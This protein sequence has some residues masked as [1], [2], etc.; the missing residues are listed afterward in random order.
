MD[1]KLLYDEKYTIEGARQKLQEVYSDQTPQ[2]PIPFLESSREDAINEIK[3]DLKEI[4]AILNGVEKL[5][6]TQDIQ[7]EVEESAIEKKEESE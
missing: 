2:M 7:S 3:S 1:K 4:I 6:K 5:P